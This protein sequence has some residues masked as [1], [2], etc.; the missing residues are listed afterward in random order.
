VCAANNNVDF[1]TKIMLGQNYHR[2]DPHMEE[3]LP[4]VFAT[5]R[6]CMHRESLTVV[7]C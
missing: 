7:V 1:L 5:T 4:M 6:A 2:L 3:K